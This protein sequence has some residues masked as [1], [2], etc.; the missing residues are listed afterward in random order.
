M[1]FFYNGLAGFVK[2]FIRIAKSAGTGL[3]LLFRLD[4]IVFA[5]KFA[6]LDIGIFCT[7]L[8][9]YMRYLIISIFY[10]IAHRAFLGFFYLDYAYN[11]PVMHVFIKVLKE[12]IYDDPS[13]P[14]IEKIAN[15][16]EESLKKSIQTSS[17]YCES[18]L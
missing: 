3:L 12:S 15:G 10:Y 14:L 11:N 8:S 7:C 2:A 16:E 9:N 4:Y 17:E 5:Q 13:I 6:F 18:C 1:L